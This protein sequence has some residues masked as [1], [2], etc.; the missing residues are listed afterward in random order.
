MQPTN[1]P[2]IN[3]SKTKSI[4][5]N[6]TINILFN[7]SGQVTVDTEEFTYLGSIITKEGGSSKDVQNCIKKA[8]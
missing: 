3:I 5:L 6:T 2:T 1:V 4:R 8:E 7:I